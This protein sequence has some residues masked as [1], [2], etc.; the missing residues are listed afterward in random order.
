VALTASLVWAGMADKGFHM[1]GSRLL[2]MS[3]LSIAL[4]LYFVCFAGHGVFR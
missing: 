2:N 4:S 3:G 1:V